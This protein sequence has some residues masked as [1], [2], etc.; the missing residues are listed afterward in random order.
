MFR[1]AA[2]FVL[3]VSCFP[4]PYVQVAEHCCRQRIPVAVVVLSNAHGSI[5][6]IACALILCGGQL[7]ETKRRVDTHALVCDGRT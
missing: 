4:F 6:S 1:A 5:E 2:I 3:L 7:S